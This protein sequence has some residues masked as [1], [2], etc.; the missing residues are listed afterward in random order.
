LLGVMIR[1][2]SGRRAPDRLKLVAAHWCVWVAREG[3]VKDHCSKFPGDSCPTSEGCER[4][5]SYRYSTQ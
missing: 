5:K 1:K 3:V 4:V 2:P